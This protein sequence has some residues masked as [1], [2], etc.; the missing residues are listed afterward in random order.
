MSSNITEHSE[1]KMNS[2]E[3]VTWTSSLY[4]F[5]LKSS[6]LSSFL[7]VNAMP[8]FSVS[9]AWQTEWQRNVLNE[10]NKSQKN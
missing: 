5:W 2:I 8:P 9:Q 3:S 4:I 10:F 6:L 1:N 7:P